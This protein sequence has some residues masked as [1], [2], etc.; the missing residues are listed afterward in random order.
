VGASPLPIRPPFFSSSSRRI[1]QV[2]IAARVKTLQFR[3]FCLTGRAYAVI[4]QCSMRW[5][6]RSIIFVPVLVF[7]A[8]AISLSCGGGGGGSS[9]APVPI[10]LTSVAICSGS[11]PVQ[12]PTPT[13]TTPPPPTPTPT[14]ACVPVPVSPALPVGTASPG[15]VLQFNAQGTFVGAN[16]NAPKFGD[17]TNNTNTLWFDS[18]GKLSYGSNGAWVGLSPGC[19][20]ITASAGG[21]QSQSISVAVA[22]PVAACTPCP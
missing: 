13:P 2:Q 4:G 8:A 22:T 6:R 7:L 18:T 9:P 16:K 5:R 19:D 10:S 14:P 3:Q 1:R 20:C 11:P 12:T 15:N 17:V 21:V